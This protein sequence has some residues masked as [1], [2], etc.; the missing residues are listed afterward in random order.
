M[1]FFFFLT[2]ARVKRLGSDDERRA[3]GV[4][5]KLLKIITSLLGED[6]VDHERLVASPGSLQLARGGKPHFGLTVH[7]GS[8]S[9]KAR[10]ICQYSISPLTSLLV[11]YG[12]N[13]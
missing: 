6:L 13:L 9:V 10:V 1:H 5:R 2:R 3:H 8:L 4:E 7:A 11:I 12:L